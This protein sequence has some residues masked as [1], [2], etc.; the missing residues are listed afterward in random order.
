M[1]S[2]K[3]LGVF[4]KRAGKEIAANI[5]PVTLGVHCTDNVKME[6]ASAKQASMENTVLFQL[7]TIPQV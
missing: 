4:A 6:A 5:A 3:D 2:A 1:D 7:A